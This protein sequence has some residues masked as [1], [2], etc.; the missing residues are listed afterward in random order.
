MRIK[1][2]LTAV[3]RKS[4]RG[5]LKPLTTI[6][7]EQAD[8]GKE[9]PLPEYPRPQMRRDQWICLNGWWEY[10]FTGLGE[11]P[12]EAEGRILVPFSPETRR[13]SVER[14][15][16]PEEALWY[17]RKVRI[18]EVPAGAR[19][20]LHFGAVDER[21][22][23]W[24]NGSRVGSHRGGYLPFQFDVTEEI[25]TG[26]NEISV[27]VRDETDRGS[28]C[29]GKQKLNPGGMFYTAQS[30]I[31]QTVWMEWVPDN[32][33]TGLKIIPRLGEQEVEFRINMN[34][35]VSGEI[36]VGKG[37][38]FTSE[39]VMLE[40]TDETLY[41]CPVSEKDFDRKSMLRCRLKLEEFRLWSPE[42]PTLYPVR[43]RLG[44]DRITTYFAMRS[45]GTGYDAGGHACLTLNEEPY[46]FHGILDQGYW[47]ES[48]MTPP[49]EESMIF[50]IKEMKQ[51]G[52][53]MLRK[54]AKIEPLRWYYHCDRIGMVV[55]QDMVNGGGPIPS[56][57]CTYLPTVVPAL[58]KMVADRHYKL[59]SRDNIRERKRFEQ[60]LI[61]MIDHLANEPCI[62]MW[63]IFNEGWGQF[64][65]VRL[66]E[67]VRRKDSTRP[68]DHASGWFDQGIGDVCS[69]HN[70]FRKLKVEK[71]RYNRPFVI[72]EYGGLAC[73]ISDH[74]SADGTYGYHDVSLEEFPDEFRTLMKTIS[75]LSKDGLAGAVYTQVSDIEEEINGLLTYDRK[76][77]KSGR[78]DLD[79][80]NK[81][82]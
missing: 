53:N 12:R 48:L 65:S 68:V 37:R 58:G 16:K 64:D 55:W 71:D 67:A 29:R 52:F 69:V 79:I 9:I 36:T 50:D 76:Y 46:F 18:P 62:G 78:I 75:D 43:I 80:S 31:W 24:V 41:I 45:F 73:R 82:S 59:L 66:T 47:P 14:T 15:L 30:G 34:R 4:A 23:V 26:E 11:I 3:F 10:T 54:H 81:I 8:D 5:Q 25:R 42:S 77:K 35:P 19:L 74:T 72:S 57:L 49:S 21:C 56:M 44:Q 1:D 33:I 17:R 38:T 60:Q 70:Y 2:A 7:T 6:W 28:A 40:E 39:E 27:R 63:V 61:G 13:S 32:F 51:V 22:T 20:L